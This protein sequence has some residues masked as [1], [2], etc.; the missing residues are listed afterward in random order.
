M[1]KYLLSGV[2][3][4]EKVQLGAMTS[5]QSEEDP[6]IDN[7][8]ELSQYFVQAVQRI[9]DRARCRFVVRCHPHKALQF[10]V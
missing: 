6:N 4:G 1:N 10:V 7:I 2:K 9:I 5:Q 8:P 3:Q